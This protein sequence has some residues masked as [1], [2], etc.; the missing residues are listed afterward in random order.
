MATTYEIIYKSTVPS[1]GAANIEF[2]SIPAT[3]TDLKLVFSARLTGAYT[4]QQYGIDLNF[5]GST[6]NFTNRSLYA[7]SG[8]SV[9]SSTGT[10]ALDTV[11]GSSVT[12]STFNNAELYIPNYTSTANAKSFSF[13][14]VS[15]NNSSTNNFLN[16]LA[17][18]WNPGTQAA[19]TSIRLTPQ[20]SNL[21]E[22][23]S[24]YL[25]GIKNS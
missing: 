7:F 11:P 25:Y 15:E 14:N 23:S 2:T 24:F 19:I 20:A 1:G 4:A 10:N 12:A 9:A 17:G 6:S 21:A 16:L 18:L 3:Y 22:Y 8:T 13:D 5:N